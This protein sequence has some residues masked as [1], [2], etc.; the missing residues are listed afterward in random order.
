MIIREATE[1]DIKD[2]VEIQERVQIEIIGIDGTG[3]I[4]HR[5][6]EQEL[7]DVLNPHFLVAENGNIKGYCMSYPK[8]LVDGDTDLADWLREQENILYAD[9]FAMR[10]PFSLGSSRTA[11]TLVDETIRRAKES[12]FERMIA[13]TSHEP[14]PNKRMQ[15]LLTEKG[16]RQIATYDQKV[17]VSLGVLLEPEVRFGV[18]ELKL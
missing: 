18:Y 15:A 16:F 12:G 4:D 17:E 6:D 3:F 13:C 7:G 14:W 10:P 2:I 1:A 5:Y 9:S 8:E 11:L